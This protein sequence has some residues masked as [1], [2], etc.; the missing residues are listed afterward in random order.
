MS[1]KIRRAIIVGYPDL[2]LKA[3]FL[4]YAVTPVPTALE[5]AA[6]LLFNPLLMMAQTKVS[7]QCTPQP[8]E[9][10]AAAIA[11]EI[12]LDAAHPATEWQQASPVTFCSDWQGK[13]PDPERQTQVRVLWSAKTLYLRFECRYRE[14]TVFTDSDPNG[15]RDHLWDR[16][17]AEAFLQPDPTRERYYKEFEV[18][19][20]GMWIDLDISPEPRADLKSG[21]QHS[22]VLDERAKTWVAELAIP[23][24]A[25]T[26]KF[27]PKALWRANFYRVE[28]AKEPRRYLAWQPTGTPE[29]NFHVPS[30]FGRLRFAAP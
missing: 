12:K 24:K 17:V 2:A 15:R 22:V 10:V 7:M 27:D 26:T 19:P 16:D 6:M 9:I 3:L 28:G 8:G 29:P 5:I 21:L 30:A 4:R 20:N 23:I 1:R 14:L 25:L 11:G 13:N 18:S